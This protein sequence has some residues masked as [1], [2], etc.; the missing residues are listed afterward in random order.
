MHA[1]V[2]LL[3][4]E[5]CGGLKTLLVN[6]ELETWGQFEGFKLGFAGAHEGVD[7]AEASVGEI[8]VEWFW[9]GRMSGCGGGVEGGGGEKYPAVFSVVGEFKILEEDEDF[10]VGLRMVRG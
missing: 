7:S 9:E 3:H 1:I 6:D 4:D 5:P 2:H 8:V 10:A